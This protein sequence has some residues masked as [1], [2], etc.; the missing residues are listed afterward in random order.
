MLTRI[1]VIESKWFTKQNV[2]VRGLFDLISDLHY[3]TPHNYHY[4]MAMSAAAMKEA[5]PRIG[6]LKGCSYLYIASHGDV[7]GVH[8]YNGD[9]IKLPDFRKLLCR[10]RETPGSKLTGLHLG[11]CFVGSLEMA[12][13]LY[14]K[15]IGLRW[16]AGYNKKINWISSSALDMLFFSELVAKGSGSSLG[17]IKHVAERIRVGSPG[18]VDELGFGIF[19]KGKGGKVINL[20]AD[21]PDDDIEEM[22]DG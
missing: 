17:L 4:E 18:L 21:E 15:D 5:L 7:D 6:A 20:L 11:S 12:E 1:A 10:V 16:V 2:S 3:D 14:K 8:L 19:V 13:Y 22:L 9:I